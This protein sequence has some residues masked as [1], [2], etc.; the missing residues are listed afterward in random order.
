M[1]SQKWALFALEVV[2]LLAAAIAG[3]SASGAMQ[4]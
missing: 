1:N 4:L 3:A 2:R